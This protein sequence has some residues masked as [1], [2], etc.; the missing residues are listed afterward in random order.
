MI[1]FHPKKILN[2]YTYFHNRQTTNLN[3]HL[4]STFSIELGWCLNATQKQEFVWSMHSNLELERD[5]LKT[6]NVWVQLI[7]ISI[8]LIMHLVHLCTKNPKLAKLQ[9]NL[10]D[11]IRNCICG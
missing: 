3:I 8:I 2:R 1:D 5:F 11:F 7:A 6:K 4:Q 9:D 10:D